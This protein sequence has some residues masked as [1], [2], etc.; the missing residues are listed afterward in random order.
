MG[1]IGLDDGE[2]LGGLDTVRNRKKTTN[3]SPNNDE[4]K[5]RTTLV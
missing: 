1:V 2:A 5:R 4:V 3:N